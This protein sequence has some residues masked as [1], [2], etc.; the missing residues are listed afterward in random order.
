MASK[1]PIAVSGV[2]PSGELH[3]GNYLG[4]IKQFVQL[5]DDY[6]AYFFIANLHALTEPQDPQTLH[7]QTIA[8]AMLYLACGLDPAKTT[9]FVQSHIPEHTE[10]GWVLN[11]ITPLGELERSE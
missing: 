10:L 1:K 11:T 8:V 3:I 2:Q 7:D 4:A 9:L 5:Q 6:H